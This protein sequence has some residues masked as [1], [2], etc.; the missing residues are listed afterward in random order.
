LHGSVY[1]SN[2][3]TISSLMPLNFTIAPLRID[4]DYLDEK[5][6]ALDVIREKLGALIYAHAL[7]R[8]HFFKATGYT[9]PSASVF[10]DEMDALFAPNKESK[11]VK[12]SAIMQQAQSKFAHFTKSE[13]DGADINLNAIENDD[14]KLSKNKAGA[15]AAVL[16]PRDDFNTTV[17]EDPRRGKVRRRKEQHDATGKRGK[18]KVLRKHATNRHGHGNKEL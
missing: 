15:G 12:Q 8:L 14:S 11:Q 4:Q 13:I 6:P 17:E 3:I 16:L 7:W 1:L 10:G 5:P 2:I 18:G 9:P